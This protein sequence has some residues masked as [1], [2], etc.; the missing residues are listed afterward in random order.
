MCERYLEGSGHIFQKAARFCARTE[1]L[2]GFE[3]LRRRQT[4]LPPAAISEIQL[5]NGP[6]VS[7]LFPS[8]RRQLCI[9]DVW[10]EVS[11]AAPVERC[12]ERH[13]VTFSPSN[14]PWNV[15]DTPTPAVIRTRV[16]AWWGGCTC[17]CVMEPSPVCPDTSSDAVRPPAD[18]M[19]RLVQTCE[20]L[21]NSSQL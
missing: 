7:G 12:E 4:S 1:T 6:E 9:P 8:A 17:T 5:R 11:L 10:T 21:Q 16:K 20:T 18:E 3:A 13:R 19:L 15:I 2:S 14:Y